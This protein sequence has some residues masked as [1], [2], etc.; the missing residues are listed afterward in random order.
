M[1]HVLLIFILFCFKRAKVCGINVH[2]SL[3]NVFF[4]VKRNCEGSE[5][6]GL[7]FLSL[8][9]L[10]SLLDN[11]IHCALIWKTRKEVFL[12]YRLSAVPPLVWIL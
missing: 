7:H 6:L 9:I 11:Y 8:R 5:P 3:R 4:V 1:Q 10:H 2:F 12:K